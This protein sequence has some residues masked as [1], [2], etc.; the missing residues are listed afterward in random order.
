[1]PR[2]ET[3]NDHGKAHRFKPGQSGNPRGRSKTAASIREWWNVLCEENE[4]GS[5]KYTVRDLWHIA[6]AEDNDETVPATKR[7]A[8]RQIIEAIKGGREGREIVSMIFDR[9]EGRPGQDLHVTTGIDPCVEITEAT[10][11]KIQAAATS[12]N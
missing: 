1:M 9:T 12:D 8:A 4:D 2:F 5:A 3:G 11:A 7:I 10:L 6:E